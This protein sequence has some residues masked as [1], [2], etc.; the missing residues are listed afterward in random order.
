MGELIDDLLEYSRMER[1]SLKL[2][3]LE[4]APLIGQLIA[5]RQSE[6]EAHHIAVR[7]DLP[8]LRIVADATGLG[9]ALRNLLENAMKF[10]RN[11]P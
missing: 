7:V 11:A 10:S 6:F 5:A 2:D 9:I 3:T 1:R 4:P 8:P